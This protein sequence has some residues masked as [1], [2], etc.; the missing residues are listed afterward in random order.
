M[1]FCSETE[2]L[3]GNRV[4]GYLTTYIHIQGYEQGA[5]AS[6][7]SCDFIVSMEVFMPAAFLS[8]EKQS[9]TPH[10]NSCSEL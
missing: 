3:N 2:D 5:V 6:F 7:W 4:D 10:S 1:V 9:T 8:Q